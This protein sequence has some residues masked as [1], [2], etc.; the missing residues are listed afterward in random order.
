MCVATTAL[1]QGSS[2]P[3]RSS[4]PG[5]GTIIGRVILP[6]G[7]TVS[8]NVKI[9]LTNFAI[10]GV[11]NYTDSNGE[12]SF[13]GLGSGTYQIEVIGDPELYDPVVETVN[14][15]PNGRAVVTIPLRR[16]TT[17]SNRPAND[18]VSVAELDQIPGP[19]KKEFDRA[20]QLIEKNDSEQAI[21]HL[22]QAIDIYPNYVVARNTLG[23]EY[24][25][26]KRLGEAAEQF[27]AALKISPKVFVSRLYLGILF[28][29]QKRYAEASSHLNEAVSVNSQHGTAHLYLGIASLGSGDLNG[30]ESSFA[31]A[32]AI[33][34]GQ[35]LL[36]H[37]YLAHVHL[38]RGENA[39]A[40]EALKTY[41]KA[42]PN[43]EQ[44]P[45]ARSLLD[46]LE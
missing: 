19:A 43:G 20:S 31:K 40:V 22:K 23:V 36:A 13:R 33:D 2:L 12:F 37:Y 34:S 10:A 46:R 35:Y 7:G 24:M 14:L 3:R 30:A 28:V 27:E 41:L 8:S 32:L 5:S 44:A 29:Q 1:A 16:K 4:L 18:V 11:V 15:P 17:T 21:K 45:H 39:K 26:V 6:S 42:A 38:K 9:R 25:K